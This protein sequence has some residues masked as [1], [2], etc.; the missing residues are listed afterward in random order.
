LWRKRR[1]A[2][3]RQDEVAK[4][5]K[6]RRLSDWFD[7]L[8]LSRL[9][10]VREDLDSGKSI[11]EQELSQRLPEG[12]AEFYAKHRPRKLYDSDKAWSEA[13]VTS[14]DWFIERLELLPG[15]LPK[16]KAEL[17]DPSVILAELE[18]EERLDAKMDKD[19]MAIGRMKTMQQMG[20]GRRRDE[21]KNNEP[22]KRVDSPPTQV[23]GL[24]HK[25]VGHD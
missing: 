4:A 22:M 7:N 12:Y 19:I 14:L 3:T 21:Q 10:R 23:E 11:S 20:L 2:R 18:V 8:Q 24:P 9:K 1:I 16:V 13:V 25:V 15:L 6:R 5:A 17:C